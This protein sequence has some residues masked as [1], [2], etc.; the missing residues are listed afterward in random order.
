[1]KRNYL[2]V[3]I[4]SAAMVGVFLATTISSYGCWLFA[5]HQREC[6]KALIRED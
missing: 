3:L 4:C 5:F 2:K 1:M 6:P